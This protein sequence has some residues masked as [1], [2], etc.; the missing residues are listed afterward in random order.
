M[1]GY[2][3]NKLF[4]VVVFILMF[5]GVNLTFFPL[6]FAG[7]HGYPRKYLDYPDVYTV[8][9]VVSSYGSLLRVFALFMFIFLLVESL[10][11]YRLVLVDNFSN[12]RPEYSYS[13]YVFGHSYQSDVYFSRRSLKN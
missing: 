6:H 11:S 3:Y 2:I 1:T 8:W 10:F 13:R 4:I 9:N 12:R 5:V 7:L